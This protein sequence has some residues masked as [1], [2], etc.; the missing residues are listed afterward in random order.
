MRTGTTQDLPAWLERLRRRI[1]R[2]RDTRDGRRRIPQGLW[3]SAVKAAGRYGLSPTARALGL[4]YYSLQKHVDATASCGEPDRREE[5]G[6]IEVAPAASAGAPECS[7]ELVHPRGARLRVQLKGMPA[8]DL[9]ALS[10]SFWD[11]EVRHGES[12]RPRRAGR[13]RT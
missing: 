8:P 6:F 2:W 12:R 9:A 7:L 11:T 10:R 1:D 13:R 3:A 5:A 4:D